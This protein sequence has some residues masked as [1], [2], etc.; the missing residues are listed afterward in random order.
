MDK[1]IFKEIPL[2]DLRPNPRNPRRQLDGPDFDELVA[3]IRQKGILEPILVRPLESGA[4]YEIVAGGR[5][6][7]AAM[8]ID[9]EAGKKRLTKV[10]CLVRELSDDEAYDIM[11]IENLQRQDLSELD[12]AHGFKEYL[13]KHGYQ[14]LP[15]LAE[16]TGIRPEYIRRHV[17]VLALPKTIVEAWTK[18]KLAFGHLE[19]LL[20]IEDEKTRKE[21]F[22]ETL[23]ERFSVQELRKTVNEMAAPLEA[24]AFDKTDC[25]KCSKNSS[26]QFGLFGLGEK[27]AT[28]LDPKCLKKKLNDWLLGNW[29]ET[30]MHKK[31]GTS[32]FRF[33]DDVRGYGQVERFYG[34]GPYK[35]CRDECPYYVTLIDDRGNCRDGYSGAVCMGD[36]K[37]MNALRSAA[38]KAQQSK[39][40]QEKKEKRDPNAPRVPWH[41]EYF[42][43]GFLRKRIPELIAAADPEDHKLKVLLL[44]SLVNYDRDAR[45]A[46]GKALQLRDHEWGPTT[47][48]IKGILE[49]KPDKIG[50]LAKAALK[51]SILEGP[52]KGNWNGFGTANRFMTGEFLGVDIAREWTANEEYLQKKTIKELNAF[53]T[54]SKIFS[55][56]KVKAY[57]LTK[58][59]KDSFAKLKKAE[60]LDLFLKSGVNLK[61]RVPK[62]ILEAKE[63]RFQ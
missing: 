28:C 59:K 26:I 15:G 62:E 54:Q 36:R 20:R 9:S 43:D 34:G 48:I 61:G 1:S 46:A 63:S 45:S 56:K 6:F 14:V 19:Q 37:C 23:Q 4:D 30:P 18:G 11:F 47:K 53:G 42:R 50:E 25:A 5:R 57:L 22:N 27:Q 31:F 49:A 52:Q 32:G 16:R 21:L 35:K 39:D 12:Q 10:P 17:A 33:E 13:D 24:Y 29:K 60:L 58:L 38:Q 41:G 40:R 51:A 8:E 55:E 44:A 2:R 7:K 3:S